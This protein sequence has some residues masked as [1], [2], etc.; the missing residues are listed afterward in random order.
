MWAFQLWKPG[1]VAVRGRWRSWRE[2]TQVKATQKRSGVS[3]GLTD[4][5]QVGPFNTDT[6]L[7]CSR[8]ITIIGMALYNPC[9]GI[10][11]INQHTLNPTRVQHKLQVSMRN[12]QSW[13]LPA[14]PLMQGASQNQ[15]EESTTSDSLPWVTV[16][17]NTEV[18]IFSAM[19][20]TLWPIM[21]TIPVD[22]WGTHLM[23]LELE[24]GDALHMHLTSEM[25]KFHFIL[26]LNWSTTSERKMGFNISEGKTANFICLV[27]VFI[28]YVDTKFFLCTFEDT[29]SWMV[30]CF[31]V[32]DSVIQMMTEREKSRRESIK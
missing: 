13:P 29:P 2:R 14:S 4:S 19:T 12:R 20:R 18:H 8:V 6:T 16:F 23:H 1:W 17:H 27:S 9:T 3:A 28:C 31:T 26:L 22:S 24:E 7:T 10:N 15:W 32:S 21:N 5:N 30:H 11:H 25:S